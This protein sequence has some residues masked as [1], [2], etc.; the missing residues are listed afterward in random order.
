MIFFFLGLSDVDR[1]K[2]LSSVRVGIEQ[3]QLRNELSSENKHSFIKLDLL[4]CTV[5]QHNRA[6]NNSSIV[7]LP[8]IQTITT[9]RVTI[10]S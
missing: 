6:D 7:L 9:T 8:V 2:R 10:A 3:K 1:V 4:L 5:Q